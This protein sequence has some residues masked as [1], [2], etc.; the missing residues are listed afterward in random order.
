MVDCCIWG[1]F[2]RPEVAFWVCLFLGE[3][4]TSQE[5]SLYMIVIQLIKNALWW[6]KGG[7]KKGNQKEK[8]SKE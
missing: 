2:S 4:E 8:L 3:K 1:G 7:K 5:K 6:T